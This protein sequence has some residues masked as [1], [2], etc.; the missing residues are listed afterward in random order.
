MISLHSRGEQNMKIEIAT[1]KME[2]VADELAVIFVFQNDKLPNKPSSLRRID[3]A[4][5]G[6]ISKLFKNKTFTGKTGQAMVLHTLGN[7]KTERILLVGLGEKK[8]FDADTLR[9]TS[10]GAFHKAK[11]SGIGD[12]AVELPE[13]ILNIPA[14]V[15][16]EAIVTGAKLSI[17]KFKKHV[18]KKDEDTAFS[19]MKIICSKR[20]AKKVEKSAKEADIIADGVALAKDITNDSGMQVHPSSIS[21]L[22]QKTAK[23]NGFKCKVLEEKEIEKKNMGGLYNVGKG[24]E[25][26]PRLVVME[27]GSK[28]HPTVAIVGK[29][30]VFDSGGLS[31]KPSQGMEVMKSDKSGAAVVIGV[32]Q[33][34]ARLKIPIHLIGIAPLAEN[35]PSGRSYKPGDVIY[36]MSGKTVEV[37]NTDA[38][39]RLI[40][41]DGLTYAHQYKPKYIIDIATLTGACMIALGSHVSGLLGNDRKLI[42]N[43]ARAGESV[44]ERLWELPLYEEYREQMKSDIADIKNVGGRFGGCITAAAF[45]S[46]FVEGHKWAH[47]DIAG[48]AWSTENRGYLNKGATA[49]G[50]RLILE[51]LRKVK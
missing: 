35:M 48:T 1:G 27:Y 6:E 29:G 11:E 41:A 31:L 42:N 32:M 40:L 23:A 38:E 33:A 36:T 43:L 18:S 49:F 20:V 2:D 30:M 37:L 50:V 16:A 24:S 4:L 21:L 17:Y 19:Q 15:Q 9:K 44:G 26:P 28:K 45:L 25:N 10:A 46:S 7:L 14:D 39:G 34:A 5:K 3:K 12:V 8:K 51:F 13:E 47:I 22:A